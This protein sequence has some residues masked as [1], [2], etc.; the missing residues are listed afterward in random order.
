MR[1]SDDEYAYTP[2]MRTFT[3]AASRAR[4]LSLA[5]FSATVLSVTS[6]AQNAVTV[7][8]GARVITGDGT[9]A[10]ENA[11]IVVNGARIEQVGRASDVKAPAG[12]ARVSLAGKTVMPTIVD[13]HVHLS[14]TREALEQDLRRRPYYGV[15]AA[16]SL[17][18]DTGDAPFEL[19]AQTLPGTARFFTAGRGIT[20]P[21][22]G[23]T[24]APYWITSPAEGRKAVQELAAKKVDIVKVWV[25]D[26]NGQYKKL[27]PEL[28]GAVIDEAH[29]NKLRVTAHLF[30]LE[31][32]KGLMRAGIDAF[33][34]GVRDRDVD[35]EFLAMVRKR[36]D[37]VLVPNMPDRGVKVDMSWLRGSL[38]AAEL[39]KLETGNTDRPDAQAAFG[40]QARNLA[41]M[42][43]AGVK[44]AMGTD[45]NNPWAPHVEMADM[46]A[47]GM[48]PAQV[49]VAATRNGAEFLRMTDSG[50]IARGKSADFIVLDANPLDDITNTRRISAVYLRGAAVNRTS[51]P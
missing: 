34:H 51:L 36:P 23:R 6:Q 7:Y 30:T 39:Q 19:R 33:A 18:Q 15:S 4:W 29:K 8:E 14:Q 25:D 47:S 20:A 3:S 17:G 24:T 35:E 11:S 50:T 37:F 40:I 10:L 32:A 42:N 9:A 12:A 48:T 46:V 28:Y 31:D 2:A 45:G 41:A 13:T 49:I 16:M 43:K 44:I 22:P 27:T 5:V 38:P 1:T 26:R 21:E